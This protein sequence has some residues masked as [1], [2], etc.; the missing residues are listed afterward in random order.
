LK[1]THTNNTL[2]SKAFPV[3]FMPIVFPDP[4]IRMAIVSKAKGDED[5]IATGLHYLHEEDPTFVVQVDALLSQ[6]VIAG[7][8]ELHLLIVTKRLKE[9]YGVDVDLTEPKI[10]YKEGIK[11]QV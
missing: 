10:P 1:D 6:T 2:S 9:K 5:R 4:V 7:Q 3:E 11:A 8:G